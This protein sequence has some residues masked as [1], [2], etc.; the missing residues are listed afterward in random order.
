MQRPPSG[1]PGHE[2]PA[3]RSEFDVLVNGEPGAPAP[4]WTGSTDQDGAEPGRP[5]GEGPGDRAGETAR[6]VEPA[7]WW[8][9]VAPVVVAA[10]LAAALIGRW[11]A[12]SFFVYDDYYN[13][14]LARA[15]GLTPGYLTEPLFQHLVPGHRLGDWAVQRFAPLNWGLAHGALLL[16][17]AACLVVL[18]AV[19]V[20]L[21]GDGRPVQP[22]LLVITF[23][24]GTTLGPMAALEWW[25]AGLHALPSTFCSLVAIW[26]WLVHRRRPSPWLLE[27]SAGAVAVGLLFYLKPLLVPVYLVLMRVL[28]LD[29]DRPLPEVVREAVAEW[30]QWL[31]HAGVVGAYLAYYL[32]HRPD[33]T[34]SAGPV[35]FVRFVF[36]AWVRNVAPGL[37]G[38]RIDQFDPLP[39]QRLILVAV[40]LLFIGLVAASIVR[41][42]QAGR[43]WGFF[44][45]VWVLNAALIGIPR[46]VQFGDSVRFHLHYFLEPGLLLA[47]T[48]A[49][50]FSG[51][52]ETPDQVRQVLDRVGTA[53]V[54][55]RVGLGLA[56]VA[57]VAHVAIVDAG[58]R[59]MSEN[60]P[61]HAAGKHVLTMRRSLEDASMRGTRTVTVLD[62]TVPDYVVDTWQA[63]FNRYSAVATITGLPVEFGQ[64]RSRMYAIDR[65]GQAKPVRFERQSSMTLADLGAQ[66]AVSPPGQLRAAPDPGAAGAGWLCG[67]GARIQ[68]TMPDAA[69]AD[70]WWLILDYHAP[71]HVD[72]D[73]YVDRGAGLVRGAG[74]G[75][76]LN[77]PELRG[78][79]RMPGAAVYGLDPRPANAVAPR[80]APARQVRIDLPASP[81]VCLGTISL[82]AMV[83][84]T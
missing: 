72:L 44:A 8:V 65:D 13:F 49:V 84:A 42:R 32:T 68:F 61:G 19:L 51:R 79:L 9:R 10:V 33:A 83:P 36:D 70:G 5:E 78:G 7:P 3:P 35:L 48:A 18:Y 17:F 16:L 26:A 63:P 31:L 45:A 52:A 53:Q 58:A 28:L 6:T 38:F 4:E 29:R 14:W 34:E 60:W 57:I 50:A 55:R 76:H 73:V 11:S 30:R 12:R 69:P 25:A 39:A 77:P 81:D 56:V 66:G 67:G 74:F 20:E 43:A 82:G 80:T 59:R 27:L 75:L 62:D 64:L 23:L 1:R 37:V 46:L 21:S 24:A 54:R 40:A 47:V 2:V 71:A 15:Q 22:R 41:S